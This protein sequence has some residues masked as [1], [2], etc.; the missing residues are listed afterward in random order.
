MVKTMKKIPL[1]KYNT[2]KGLNLKSMI[3]R[4]KNYKKI[5]ILSQ[6]AVL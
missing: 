6:F 5:M 4:G 3:K 1:L 2:I